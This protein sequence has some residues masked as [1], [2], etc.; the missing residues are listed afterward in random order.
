MSEVNI[1]LFDPVSRTSRNGGLELLDEWKSNAGTWVWVNI[2]GEADGTEAGLL[3][4]R[5]GVPHLAIQD[6]F[7]DRHPPKIEVFDKQ[8]FILLRDLLA[9]DEAYQYGVA[10]LSLFFGADFLVTRQKCQTPAL[11]A[12]LETIGSQPDRLQK[13][14]AHLAYLISRR[15]VDN[16]TPVVLEF[17][18]RLAEL[19]DLIFDQ[20]GD[21]VIEQITRFNRSLKR[22]R[23][24][25]VYQRDVMRLL[26][27]PATTLP[28]KLN[29]HEFN[30]VFENMERLASLC[31]LNQELAV[32]LLNTHFSLV[33]HRLNNV[34]RIL[35][36][37]TVIFLPLALLAGIYGMNFQFMP[38]LSW[39][40]GYFGVLGTM[41]GIVLVLIAVFKRRNWL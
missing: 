15:V 10:Q 26:S 11:D 3:S 22:L 31:Q 32:D 41:V 14:P 20:P 39:H 7:R 36:I 33:S 17:E 9:E 16:Y 25:L 29:T 28:V 6:A 13:G 35:T 1:I 18:E 4:E 37:T 27:N 24:H 23:R 5:F 38:E 21:D 34:M 40:Y 30:D 12:V 19:E 8:I 2:S